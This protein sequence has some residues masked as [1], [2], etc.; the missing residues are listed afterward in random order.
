VTIQSLAKLPPIFYLSN[1]KLYNI[2]IPSL[3][4]DNISNGLGFSAQDPKRAVMEQVRQ[5]AAMTN[6]KQLIEVH[7]LR[8]SRIFP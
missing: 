1:S 4:M 7:L 3:K 2:Y 6:A 5:E 8:H